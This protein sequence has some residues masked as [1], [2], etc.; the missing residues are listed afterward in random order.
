MRP[1]VIEGVSGHENE[2]AHFPEEREVRKVPQ[3]A[4]ELQSEMSRWKA[5]PMTA[6]GRLAWGT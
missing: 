6:T 4:S 1:E 3:R 2:P 5:I